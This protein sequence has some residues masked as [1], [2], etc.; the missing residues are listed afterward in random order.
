ML[1]SCAIVLACSSFFSPRTCLFQNTLYRLVFKSCLLL[2][3]FFYFI[4]HIYFPFSRKRIVSLYFGRDVCTRLG[5]VISE[6]F[7]PFVFHLKVEASRYVP[8]P[9]NTTSELA[10]LFSTTSP[11]CQAPKQGS[12]EYHFLKSFG[13]TRHGDLNPRSTDC[14]ADALTTTPPCSR[15]HDI[16]KVFK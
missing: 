4:R 14:E 8:C 12:C 7:A 5:V 11:K 2:L 6:V 16:P 3:L 13:L 15:S 10:G 9:K 1:V